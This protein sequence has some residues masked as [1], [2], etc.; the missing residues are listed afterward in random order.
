MSTLADAL[1]NYFS[2]KLTG[3]FISTQL[4]HILFV[5]SYTCLY[6]LYHESC[7]GR[8]IWHQVHGWRATQNTTQVN[9]HTEEKL[10]VN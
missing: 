9:A 1:V 4:D 7:T 10:A 2:V 3:S 5:G 8:L 6:S